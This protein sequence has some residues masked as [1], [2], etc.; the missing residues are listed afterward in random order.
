[1]RFILAQEKELRELKARVARTDRH[2]SD[3]TGRKRA[4]DHPE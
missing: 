1:M 2:D 3:S 4:Q